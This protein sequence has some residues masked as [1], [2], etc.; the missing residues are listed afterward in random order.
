MII[1]L[2]QHIA[3]HQ[4]SIDQAADRFEYRQTAC[5]AVID[6]GLQ[7]QRHARKLADRLDAERNHLDG[8]PSA[9][10]IRLAAMR[11]DQSRSFAP[12][13]KPQPPAPRSPSIE[14]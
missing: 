8:L 7:E 5:R 1:R 10:E 13:F 2:D 12:A 11:A 9:A 3:L 4:A 6:H 14:I